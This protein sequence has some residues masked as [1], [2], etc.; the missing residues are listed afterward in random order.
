M[1]DTSHE[2][3]YKFLIKFRSVRLTTISIFQ[4]KVVEKIKTHFLCSITFLF[5]KNRFI[6]EKRWKQYFR[7]GQ[8]T[9]DNTAH[10]LCTPDT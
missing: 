6:S 2:D 1:S 4:T 5:P 10:A 8:A 3:Q 9:D 7:A